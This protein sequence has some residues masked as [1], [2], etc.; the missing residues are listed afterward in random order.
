MFNHARSLLLN[1]KGSSSPGPDFP[2]EELVPPEYRPIDTTGY[3]ATVRRALFGSSP[4]RAMLNYRL[5]QYMALLHSTELEQYVLALDPRITYDVAA[6]NSLVTNSV[7]FTPTVTQLTGLAQSNLFVTGTPNAPD[8]SGQ[9][10]YAFDIQ[11]IVGG[12]IEVVKTTPKPS[13]TIYQPNLLNDGYTSAIPLGTTGY[14]VRVLANPGDC[15]Q[16]SGFLRPQWDLGQIAVQFE[17]IGDTVLAELLGITKDEP[18]YTFSNLWYQHEE[19]AYKL[20]A[21]LMALVYRMEAVR[22]GSA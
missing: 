9:A 19:L 18:Y 6:E 10:Y 14:S 21:I 8:V 17:T 2:G 20:G 16:V 13:L 22:N 3:L 1:L 12:D 11:P 15:W 7:Y 4:D 5:K